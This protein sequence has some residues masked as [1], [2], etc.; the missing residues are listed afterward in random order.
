MKR[1]SE[2]DDGIFVAQKVNRLSAIIQIVAE[3]PNWNTLKRAE[4][5]I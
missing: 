3:S 1:N 4:K 2:K 5:Y